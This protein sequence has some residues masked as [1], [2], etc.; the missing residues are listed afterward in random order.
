MHPDPVTGQMIEGV[1]RVRYTHEA[2]ANMVIADPSISQ[3]Q[4]ARHFGYSV[5][6]I[7]RIFNSDAFQAYLH[8]RIE[9]LQDPELRARVNARMHQIEEQ[10][11]TIA[12]LSLNRVIS[13]LSG[14]DPVTGLPDVRPIEDD[15]L[16]KTAQMAKDALGFGAKP[17][18]GGGNE[19]GTTINIIQLPQK[20]ASSAEWAAQYG[21]TADAG[22]RQLP[23]PAVIELEPK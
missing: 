2:M 14:E 5:G 10:L 19:S 8:S 7:S 23:D 4:I 1:A 16:L 17:A 20:A 15:F 3:N 13:R 18:G 6:W 9:D 12:D 21:S 22:R 11:K